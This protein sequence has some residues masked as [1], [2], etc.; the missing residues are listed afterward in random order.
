VNGKDL[1]RLL[2]GGYIMDS[3]TVRYWPRVG[4]YVT[5]E[6]AEEWIE[7]LAGGEGGSTG[8]YLEEDIEE[9]IQPEIP[10]PSQLRAEIKEL[11]NNPF[12]MGELDDDVMAIIALDKFE[13]SKLSRVKQL[14]SE[15]HTLE[16]AKEIFQQELDAATAT[17]LGLEDL[18]EGAEVDGGAASSDESE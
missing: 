7:R 1:N 13:K 10:R 11:F 4:M 16:D 12:E 15:G 3:E 8:K 6:F 14:K 17:I 2:V 18:N 5:L 9:Y